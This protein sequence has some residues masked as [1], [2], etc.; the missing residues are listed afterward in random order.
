MH[1]I[2]TLTPQI[3]PKSTIIILY[4]PTHSIIHPLNKSLLMNLLLT[5][6]I[7][8]YS[9]DNSLIHPITQS[10]THSHALTHS[11][12]HY[13]L[14]N[15][16]LIHS[17]TR[18]IQTQEHYVYCILLFIQGITFPV[19]ESKNSSSEAVKIQNNCSTKF[20]M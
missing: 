15:S 14:D 7:T 18:S 10:I 20:K 19:Y 4:L 12:I 17:I 8:Y 9:L 3:I 13:S 11:I 2:I 1:K 16:L 5:H 6:L